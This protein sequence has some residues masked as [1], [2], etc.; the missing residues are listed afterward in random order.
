[1]INKYLNMDPV[2]W[3]TDGNNPAVTYH[4]K[5]EILKNKDCE[6]IYEELIKSPLTE[7]FKK[8]FFKG[9]LGDFKNPDIFYRG[10]VWFFLLAA[11]SGYKNSS[12]FISSTADWLCDK[13]QIKDGGFKFN[14]KSPEAVGCRSGNMIYALLKSGFN[15]YRTE[16]GVNWIIKNQRKDGGWLHCPVAGLC[17]V[18]K[19][20]FFSKSGNGLKHEND[21]NTSSC[22]V[23][24][25]SCLKALIQSGN[26]NANDTIEKGSDYFIKNNFFIKTEKKLQ[27]AIN[28]DFEKIGYPVMSQYDYLSGMILLLRRDGFKK[29]DNGELFNSIIKKQNQDG[30]WNLENN[31]PGMIKEKKGIS[32]W[33]TLNVLRFLRIIVEQEIQFE[34]A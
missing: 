6:K 16:I 13:T 34:K 20:V 12:D 10:S 4:V 33:T 5:N 15:D 19:L 14:Y 23:A 2:P 17:D 7:Y 1:M 32:R 25:Y 22:P 18:M 30:S 9:V 11:E 24:S 28:V 8:N 26:I 3:L 27:C 21:V 29:F 31:F